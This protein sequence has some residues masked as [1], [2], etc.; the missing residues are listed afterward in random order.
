MH[1]MAIMGDPWCDRSIELNGF[2][3]VDQPVEGAHVAVAARSAD[4]RPV[5]GSTEGKA[6][7]EQWTMALGRSIIAFGRVEHSVTLLI[8]QCTS[9]ALGY[10]MAS[11]DL[12]AR[13]TYLD[14]LLRGCGL[15]KVEERNWQRVY[16]KIGGL[17]AKY[18]TVLASG[19]PP[20]GPIEFTGSLVIVRA[21]A[22]GR[23]AENVLS[24]PQIELASEYIAA[25]HAQFVRTSGEI[26]NRLVAEGRL[27]SS[28]RMAIPARAS[29][30]EIDARL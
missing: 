30:R 15:T 2:F 23:Q 21:R 26:L 25:A 1:A 22:R 27:P 10:K 24:L 8:R 4:H 12:A 19:A 14:K 6:D 9:D 3:P 20:A 5:N 16:K 11:L 18:R 29:P 13:L 28:A 7:C 17:S